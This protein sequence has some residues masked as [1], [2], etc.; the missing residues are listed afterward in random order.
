MF[1]LDFQRTYESK[2]TEKSRIYS[3]ECSK[4]SFHYESI[5]L[6]VA[7]NGFYSLNSSNNTIR[8]YGYI[9]QDQFDPSYPHENLLTQSSFACNKHRFYLGNILEK[10]RIYILIV[11]TLYP[12]VRG[13]FQLLVTGPSNVTFKR[14]SKSTSSETNNEMSELVCVDSTI[15]SCVVGDQCNPY[16]KSIGLTMNDLLRG[17]I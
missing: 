10:N 16:R 8:L 2:L 9:Y 15:S 7:E 11:T 6:I 4:E 12:N 5:E 13:S 17:Q 3:R 14:I 1:L